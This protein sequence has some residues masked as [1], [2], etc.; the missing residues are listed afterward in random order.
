M[1]IIYFI[2]VLVLVIYYL[3]R[4][5]SSFSSET[6]EYSQ[7]TTCG[8]AQGHLPGSNIILTNSEKAVL[9]QKFAN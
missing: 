1:T 8:Q 3:K 4:S 2:L 9:N 6:V 7:S 5:H